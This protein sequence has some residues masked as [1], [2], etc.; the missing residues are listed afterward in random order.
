MCYSAASN[1]S[2]VV[3]SVT[4]GRVFVMIFF[5]MYTAPTEIYTYGHTLSLPDALPIY[6]HDPID[7][8]GWL[9]VDL[10]QGRPM[11]SEQNWCHAKIQLRRGAAIELDLGPAGCTAFCRRRVVHVGEGDGALELVRSFTGKEDEAGMGFG[12][13]DGIRAI[14]RGI[15]EQSHD[16]TLVVVRAGHRGLLHP[17]TVRRPFVEAHAG[18]KAGSPRPVRRPLRSEERRV[19]K[20]CVSTCR[21]RWSTYH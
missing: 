19:G 20:E 6:D 15:A 14:G 8:V 11:V 2:Y 10:S 21:S 13:F 5:F 7:G 18:R 17:P 1:S 9:G 12:P 4:G 3:G 16:W